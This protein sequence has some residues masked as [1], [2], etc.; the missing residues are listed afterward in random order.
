MGSPPR[1]AEC[2][3]GSG[4][5]Y[6]RCCLAAEQRE[7]QAARFEDAVGKRISAWATA[8]FPEEVDAALEHGADASAPRDDPDYHALLTW[9][10]SDREFAGG[11]TPSERYAAR[12]DIDARERDVAVRIAAARLSLQRVRAAQAGR[13]IE[14]EDVLDESVVR[15]RSDNVSREV[16]RWDVLLCRLMD[17]EEAPSLWGPV[18]LFAPAEEPELTAELER[19]ADA[20]GIHGD[21]D[22]FARVLHVAALELMRF[23]PASRRVEPSIYTVEGD[24]VV[25]GRA[26]WNV[27]D[28]AAVLE[29]LDSPPE[30]AWVGESEDGSGETF[31]LTAERAKL[32]ARRGSLPPGAICSESSLTELPGRICLATLDLTDEELRCSAISEARLEAAIELVDERLGP[33]AELIERTVLPLESTLSGERDHQPRRREPTPGRGAA[34]T[35]EFEGGLLNDHFRDWLDQPLQPL[36]G[37]T[38]REAARG[39]PSAELELLLR[40]IENRAERSRR[41]GIPWPDVGWLRDELGLGIDQLAA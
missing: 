32:V 3:C 20:H 36:G 2:P 37:R 35:R 1:N 30:L 29:L 10:C 22:R 19:L 28:P 7:R 15:V 26:S 5:K 8:Q 21:S 12:V 11:G 33:R 13:W 40:G 4:R 6:K 27:A 16:G 38:P 39:G 34:E 18:M 14:L 23:V 31:Q 17:G 25:D 9:F 41:K 24:P